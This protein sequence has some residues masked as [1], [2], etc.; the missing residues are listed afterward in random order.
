MDTSFGSR[1]RRRSWNFVYSPERWATHGFAA[2]LFRLLNAS[3]RTPEAAERVSRIPLAARSEVSSNTLGTRDEESPRPA[4]ARAARYS[5]RAPNCWSVTRL[6]W[7]D[8]ETPRS[9]GMGGDQSFSG[10]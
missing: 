3:R 6:R 8:P 4:I 2:A 7:A 5:G 10:C 9:S 1:Y